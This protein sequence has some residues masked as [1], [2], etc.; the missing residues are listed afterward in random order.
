[1]VALRHDV[2]RR[3][4]NAGRCAAIAAGLG[5]RGT[6]YFRYPYTFDP[7]LIR[8]VQ[9][10]GHEV[11]YHYEVMS[12]TRGGV[13]EAANLFATELAEFRRICPV[14]T[15]C[16]HGAP[17]SPWDNR[18]LWSYRRLEDFGLVAEPYLSVD[19]AKVG[20]LTDTGRGWNR[21]DVAVRDRA[22]GQRNLRFTS[23]WALV[24]AVRRGS[25]PDRLMLTL[26]PERWND[27][28]FRWVG[29]LVGQAARN[30]VKRILI[31]WRSRTASG[32]S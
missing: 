5:V 23:T 20:Y 21:S 14:T 28:Y 2:D 8:A 7:V 26:H 1:M 3:P 32:S 4:A 10:F 22:P 11:G 24:E 27:Q 31:G 16:M 19:F 15:A 25:V 13:T 30:G 17:L 12:K 18:E 6:F 9:R 29:D